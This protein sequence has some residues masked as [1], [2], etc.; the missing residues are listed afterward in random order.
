MS[1]KVPEIKRRN[2][3]FLY[4]L[5]NHLEI[6]IIYYVNKLNNGAIPYWKAIRKR[7][8]HGGPAISRNYPGVIDSQMGWKVMLIHYQSEGNTWPR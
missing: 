2:L 5:T 8:T 4:S 1:W 3:K 6:I 7:K